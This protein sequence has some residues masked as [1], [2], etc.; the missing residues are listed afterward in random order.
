MSWFFVAVSVG[1]GAL[2]GSFVSGCAQYFA[3]AGR[4]SL[5]L[6]PFP[7][8]ACGAKGA[9]SENIPVLSWLLCGRCRRCGA[10]IPLRRPC[11]ELTCGLWAGL[12]AW[13]LGFGAAWAVLLPLGLLLILVSCIDLETFLLPDSYVLPG[14]AAAFLAAVL[15][16]NHGGFW[17]RLSPSLWG[18]GLGGGAFLFLHLAWKWL[19]GV[20]GLGLGD[21]KLMVLIG[22][23]LGPR[24]L[25]LVTFVA[26]LAA[27]PTS[28]WWPRTPQEQ[29]DRV[30]FGPFLSLGALVWILGGDALW[31]YWECFGW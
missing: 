12:L 19:T 11:I 20:D 25:A 4:C 17:Q 24:S 27:L 5:R 10:R 15:V 2:G 6:R 8:A 1:L 18:A 9:W 29:G 28:L 23:L 14:I 16:L 3:L 22:A 7:C 13:R 21:V 30:P 31:E 26:V